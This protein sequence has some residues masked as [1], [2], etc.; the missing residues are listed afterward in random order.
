MTQDSRDAI[1]RDARI[2]SHSAPLALG[3]GTGT[4]LRRFLVD[5][6]LR[7]TNGCRLEKQTDGSVHVALLM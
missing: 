2:R 5:Y 6:Y 4:R 3:S 1:M 7:I